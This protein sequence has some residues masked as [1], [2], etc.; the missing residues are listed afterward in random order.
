MPLHIFP[1]LT[2]FGLVRFCD[3]SMIL[4]HF[5]AIE[6]IYEFGSTKCL[7]LTYSYFLHLMN[8][9]TLAWSQLPCLWHNGLIAPMTS[10][11]GVVI[12]DTTPWI[13]AMITFAS[14]AQGATTWLPLALPLV[15][16]CCCEKELLPSLVS[17]SWRLKK[18]WIEMMC[19]LQMQKTQ[20]EEVAHA[21]QDKG[22]VHEM[23]IDF[24]CFNLVLS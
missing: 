22:V 17:I 5:C 13:D 14:F 1:M 24:Q 21:T 11:N 23:S 2:I 20:D 19:K 3:V 7:K 10:T 6:S 4:S 15:N 9:I 16:S 12:D 8:A 18:I